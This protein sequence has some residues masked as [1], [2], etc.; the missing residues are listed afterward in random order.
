[1]QCIGGMLMPQQMLAPYCV[2]FGIPY[3]QLNE[4]I[5]KATRGQ[6]G[7]KFQITISVGPN[8]QVTV[9]PT[10]GEEQPVDAEASESDD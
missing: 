9:Y 10:E 7:K 3:N 2:P 5:V 8:K 4:K 6:K 1:M